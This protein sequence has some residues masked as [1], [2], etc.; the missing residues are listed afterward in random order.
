MSHSWCHWRP[1]YELYTTRFPSGDQ[2][3]RAFQ[4]V[5]SY[6][7]SRIGAP[8]VAVMRQNPAVP[9]MCPRFATT[10]SSRP[11]GGHVGEREWS[12][13]LEQERGNRLALSSVSP[14]TV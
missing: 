3:G 11:S 5:S 7:S 12:H 1:R 13:T 9:W 14:L 2:S 8:G 4:V 10:I 6:L